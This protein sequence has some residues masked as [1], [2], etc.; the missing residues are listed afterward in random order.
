MKEWRGC[1]RLIDREVGEAYRVGT[2]E[3]GREVGGARVLNHLGSQKQEAGRLM[4]KVGLHNLEEA[5][6]W[7][8]V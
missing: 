4:S 3:V 2:L 7:G 5:D 6:G 8:R 1:G